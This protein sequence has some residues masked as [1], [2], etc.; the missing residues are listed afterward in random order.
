[1]AFYVLHQLSQMYED[2]GIDKIAADFKTDVIDPIVADDTD[3]NDIEDGFEEAENGVSNL[4][5]MR[6]SC[7]YAVGSLASLRAGNSENSWVG[8]AHAQ[9]WMGVAFGAGFI[10]GARKE[11]LSERA[12]AGGL[13][14]SAK[15]E[16]LRQ[17]ARGLAAKRDYKSRLSAAIDLEKEVIAEAVRLDI[18]VKGDTLYRRIYQWLEGL[19]F[20]RDKNKKD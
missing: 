18:E 10:K 11:A 12:A 19:S 5:M 16:P 20:K 1:M 9:Y 6:L 8:I 2:L 14:R 4:D 3:P 13:A 17:F 15:F 7:A